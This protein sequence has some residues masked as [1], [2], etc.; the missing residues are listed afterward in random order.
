MPGPAR[1][2]V[3]IQ[4]SLARTLPS[5]RVVPK[6]IAVRLDAEA[7]AVGDRGAASIAFATCP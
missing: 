7:W 2:S 6:E 5:H 3:K 4:R 1:A